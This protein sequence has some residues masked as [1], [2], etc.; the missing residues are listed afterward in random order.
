[1]QVASS[2]NKLP[3][4]TEEPPPDPDQPARTDS[5][6]ETETVATNTSGVPADSSTT[7]GMPDTAFTVDDPGPPEPAEDAEPIVKK[8]ELLPVP[9]ADALAKTLAEVKEIFAAEYA[10]AKTYEQRRALA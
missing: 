3:V 4:G 8:R 7:S 6:S 2:N 9:E 5:E 10:A 1:T